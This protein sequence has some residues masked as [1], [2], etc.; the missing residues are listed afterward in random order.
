VKFKMPSIIWSHAYCGMAN[1]FPPFWP[2]HIVPHPGQTSSP[3]RRPVLLAH[4]QSTPT[5]HCRPPAYSCLHHTPRHDTSTVRLLSELVTTP[6]LQVY[7]PGHFPFCS[8]IYLPAHL[9]ALH[10]CPRRIDGE[11][12]A[13]APHTVLPSSR[14][15]PPFPVHHN[16]ISRQG[17]LRL[18]R[19]PS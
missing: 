14:R 15:A 13:D 8:L 1:C 17:W 3:T 4:T 12:R 18:V 11:R 2:H 16:L 5:I 10:A 7:H 9:Y 19:L 6:P